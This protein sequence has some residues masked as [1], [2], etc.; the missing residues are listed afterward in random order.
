[1]E[2]RNASDQI[3]YSHLIHSHK[4]IFF[5][6]ANG[7]PGGSYTPLFEALKPYEIAYV[8]S[9]SE[10]IEE[11][12]PGLKPLVT[13][14]EKEIEQRFDRPI[15]GM[16]HSLG[17]IL[18]FFVAKKRPELFE[19]L[20]LMDP[21]FF[22]PLKRFFVA[23][24]GKTGFGNIVPVAAKAA[25]RRNEFSSPEEAEAYYAGRGLFKHTHPDTVPFY[26]KHGLVQKDSSWKL[27]IPPAFER[28]VY[29][30][31][32]YKLDYDELQVASTF[33]YGTRHDV[34]SKTDIRWLKGNF[35]D[36]QFIEV[37]GSHMF[38]LERPG[39]VAEVLKGI[40]D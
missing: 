26:V 23:H 5:A 24:I 39:L 3:Y 34:L 36:T 35:T 27:S 37:E 15:I 40:L 32:P 7:F 30:N 4:P 25:K 33:L 13:K 2:K 11:V 18:M 38:P 16:G 19:H 1:M 14:L 17:G 6:H 22:R 29:L 8:N 10:D 21:P 20:V 31:L 28:A 12:Q 9:I